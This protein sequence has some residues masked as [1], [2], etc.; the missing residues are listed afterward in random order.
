MEVIKK[1]RREKKSTK[2]NLLWY[3]MTRLSMI[4]GLLLLFYLVISC[5]INTIIQQQTI[6]TYTEDIVDTNEDQFKKAIQDADEYNRMLYQTLGLS[7]G[8]VTDDILTSEKYQSLLNLSGNGIMGSIEIPQINVALPIYHG[9]SDEV[10]SNG[11]GHVENTS[12]PVGGTNTRCVLSGHRGLPSSNLFTRLDELQNGDLFF[13]NVA[14]QTLAYKIYDIQVIEP[15]DVDS[16]AIVPEKDLVS[17]VTCTPYGKNTHRLVITGERVPYSKAE[18]EDIPV[19]KYSNREIWLYLIVA[20]LDIA[21]L[22][23]FG[24]DWYQTQQKKKKSKNRNSLDSHL[25]YKD[26]N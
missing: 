21:I 4:V 7:I 20:L 2:K 6:R 24:F 10:L 9:T 3:V 8:G 16:I 14:N 11:I 26:D 5:H 13:I 23:S 1:V 17:L 18:K 15:E 19:R 25:R 12:L 22:G